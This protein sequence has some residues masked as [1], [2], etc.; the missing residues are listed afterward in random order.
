[1]WMLSP[2][3]LDAGTCF[4][5]RRH[6]PIESKACRIALLLDAPG[7][8]ADNG[9]MDQAKASAKA[10][11]G[12]MKGD[13]EVAL[14]VFFECGDIRTVADFTTDPAPLLA[15]LEPIQPSGGTPL[16]ASIGMAKEH[17]RVNGVG[18][19]RRLVVLT[20]GAESCDGDLMDAATR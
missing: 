1:M 6:T 11:I 12:N 3:A 5:V 10:V 17:L 9:R 16:D 14:I 8:M 13:F 4:D 19:T 18:A 15:A 7:S 2:K 20:D